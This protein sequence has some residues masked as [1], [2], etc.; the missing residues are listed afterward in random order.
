MRALVLGGCGFI[1][2]HVVDTLRAAGHSVTVFDRAPE[3]YRGPVPDVEYLLGDFTDKMAVAEALNGQDVVFHLIST[4]FPGTANIDPKADVSGNLIGTLN[5]IETMNALGIRRLVYL[6]SGGTVYGP[7][8]GHPV[9]EDFPLNPINSYGIVKVAIEQYLQMYRT[10]HGLQ[11]IAIR[12]ANPFGTRQGHAGVQGVIATFMRRMLDRQP[13]E[14]WGDGQVVRDYLHVSDLAAL[15]LV[16]AQSDLCGAIN[17]GSGQ[18]RSL[19]DVIEALAEVSGQVIEPSFK[20][21][22]KIDVPYSVL[23]IAKAKDLLGWQ[24]TMDF[25]SG[26]RSTWEWMRDTKL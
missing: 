22:R 8:P 26:L 20:A 19:L 9:P 21:G 12:A 18:G 23:D 7:A 1:G 4:T 5:L 2:S 6:S 17:A 15:C 25:R 10:T 16:A 14:I 3:R 11:P 13:I 24:P